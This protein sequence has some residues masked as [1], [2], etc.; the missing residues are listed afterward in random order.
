MCLK[1]EYKPIINSVCFFFQNT[2][3]DLKGPNEN[4][5]LYTND[6]QGGFL[7]PPHGTTPAAV[8]ANKQLSSHKSSDAS[9]DKMLQYDA[10]L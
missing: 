3:T 6:I 9:G 2:L 4:F 5:N 7:R 10:I 1:D 8:I